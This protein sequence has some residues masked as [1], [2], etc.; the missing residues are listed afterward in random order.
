MVE[1]E[2]FKKKQPIDFS[3]KR[4]FILSQGYLKAFLVWPDELEPQVS[5]LGGKE[6]REGIFYRPFFLMF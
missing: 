6:E 5:I 1:L 4:S 3:F 2:H